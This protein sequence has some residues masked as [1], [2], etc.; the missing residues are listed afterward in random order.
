MLRRLT[1]IAAALALVACSDG[2]SAA[3]LTP[4]RNVGDAVT[5]PLTFDSTAVQQGG[6]PNCHGMEQFLSAEQLAKIP[7]C[8][9]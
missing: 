5:V 8:R 3:T 1:I 9:R 2:F 6:D 4:S 7:G